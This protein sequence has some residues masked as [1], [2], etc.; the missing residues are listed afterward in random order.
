M[1]EAATAVTAPDRLRELVGRLARQEGFGEVLASLAAGH[2][3][4][5]DG[6]WGSSCALVAATLAQHAPG[7]LVVVCPRADEVDALADDL[8]LFVE[9]AAEQF[10]ACEARSGDRVVQDEAAGSRLRLLKMLHARE[11]PSLLA[12]SIQALLQPVPDRDAL[13]RQTRLLRVGQPLSLDDLARWLV[14][15]RFHATTGVELPGEFSRRGGIID[16][17]APDWLDPVRVELL[18]DE[19]ESI[20]RFEVASQRSLGGLDAMEVTVIDPLAP[21]RGHFADFLPPES[22]FLLLEPGELE[23]EGRHYLEHLERPQDLHAVS[24]VLRQVYRF[25]SV[26]AS[27]VAAG[28]L[29]TTC[30]LKI[31]SVE[32]FSGDINKV[33]DELDEAGAGQEVFLVCQ[34]E[35]EVR[36]LGEIFAATKLAQQGRIHF[37]LGMLHQG[38]R[39][40]AEGV[41]LLGSGELFRRTDLRRPSRRRLGRVIDSFLELHEG[42]LVVHV[43]HGI[44][45]YRGLT[46][47]EKNGQVEEHLELEFQGRTKLYVPS[48]KIGLVQKYVGGSKSRPTLARLGGHAW[49]RQKGQ[50]EAAVSDLAAEM[51][52]LQA[53]RASRPGITFPVETE[54]QHEFDASFP[55]DETPDQLTTMEAIKRDMGQSRPMDR[56]LCGDVGYGKTEIAMRASFT[57]VDAGYQVALLVPTTVLAEQH[58]RTFTARMAE[59]PFEIAALSRFASRRQQARIIDRLA[60][61]AVDVV[62]GTH[63]LVQPDVKFHNL[64]LVIIDEEQRFGVEDKEWLKTL[65]TTVDVLTLSAR[66]FLAPCT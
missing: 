34:T 3:A 14:E 4:T 42:D 41:V 62:I 48:S 10:P 17:F 28:S 60:A 23:M 49:Q 40:V 30:R 37:P 12:T 13:A 58:L 20:R 54:W 56:L 64:G 19:I 45:R 29:E 46:L 16:I 44:A 8:G 66:R 21:G 22:W 11:R 53:S 59:F 52:E 65:R 25:P 33:R 15:N 36:R 2:A 43:A 47:L 9:T 1:A 57:A 18:G 63:R 55:Y 61:G 35:A 32:R 50:V 27:A 26:T 5:L 7:P 6:V 38:F 51:L 39:L 31:E 24:D